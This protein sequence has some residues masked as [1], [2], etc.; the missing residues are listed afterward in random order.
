MSFKYQ[1][2]LSTQWIPPEIKDLLTFV[3]FKS[4][5][6]IYFRTLGFRDFNS[7]L[8]RVLL[9]EVRD[10]SPCVPLDMTIQIF[11]GSSGFGSLNSQFTQFQFTQSLLF[12][13]TYP[14]L[15]R[16]SWKEN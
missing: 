1:F 3:L 8:P 7:Q 12:V 11:F 6:I 13:D 4:M 5:V 14:S 9:S 10:M 15:N 2:L 16:L